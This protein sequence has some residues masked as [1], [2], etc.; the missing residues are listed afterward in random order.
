[1]QS[2]EPFEIRED[3]PNASASKTSKTPLLV[4]Q[5]FQPDSLACQA[6]KPDLQKCR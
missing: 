5:A 2:V 6:G 3:L 1:M 4:G